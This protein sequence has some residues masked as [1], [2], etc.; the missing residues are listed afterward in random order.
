MPQAAAPKTPTVCTTLYSSLIYT[1]LILA[2]ATELVRCS[3][4]LVM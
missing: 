2:G 4:I 3:E 1:H